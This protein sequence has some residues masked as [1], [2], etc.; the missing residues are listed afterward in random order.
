MR[1]HPLSLLW[2]AF[3]AGLSHTKVS[4]A[5]WCTCAWLESCSIPIVHANSRLGSDWIDVGHMTTLEPI[6]VTIWAFAQMACVCVQELEEGLDQPLWPHSWVGGR[7]G[8]CPHRNTRRK[9]SFLGEMM[10]LTPVGHKVLNFPASYDIQLYLTLKGTR[11]AQ[12][13]QHHE[14]LVVAVS[15][16]WTALHARVWPMYPAV[17]LAG[18]WNFSLGTQRTPALL[19]RFTV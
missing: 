9:R 4:T 10:P 7:E 2:A 13:Y 6:T 17:K 14:V 8:K 3:S 15:D 18:S 19:P 1:F 16:S 11:I 12:G 5:L